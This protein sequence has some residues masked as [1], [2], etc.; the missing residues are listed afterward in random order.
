MFS[1]ILARMSPGFGFISCNSLSAVRMASFSLSAFSA[2]SPWSIST[3]SKTSPPIVSL[4][5]LRQISIILY[6]ALVPQSESFRALLKCFRATFGFPVYLGGKCYMIRD[7]TVKGRRLFLSVE[8]A[9][10]VICKRKSAV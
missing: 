10:V 3:A 5:G 1:R 4:S 9:S 8:L 2:D 7:Q 6:I